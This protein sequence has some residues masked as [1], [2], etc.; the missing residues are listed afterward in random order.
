MFNDCKEQLLIRRQAGLAHIVL[1]IQEVD[2]LLEV[3]DHYTD[4][5]EHYR[6]LLA[7]HQDIEYLANELTEILE[8]A[9]FISQRPLPVRKESEQNGDHY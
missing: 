8:H 6:A 3:I 4:S 1:H 2:K 5:I 9:I 7:S